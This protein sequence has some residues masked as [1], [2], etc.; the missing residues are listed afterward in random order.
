MVEE[1]RCYNRWKEAGS[2]EEVSS[3]LAKFIVKLWIFLFMLFYFSM[4]SGLVIILLLD[5]MVA[6]FVAFMN[7]V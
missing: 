6:K 5:W 4:Y 1:Q 7:T 3:Q 2:C